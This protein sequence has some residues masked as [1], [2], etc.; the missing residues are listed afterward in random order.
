[1]WSDKLNEGEA[2]PLLKSK[3]IERKCKF[4]T[5]IVGA[6]PQTGAE[7]DMPDCAVKWLPPLLLEV[8]KETRQ[9]AAATESFR[10]AM[11]QQNRSIIKLT[12]NSGDKVE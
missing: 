4:F 12:D 8:I 3:C 10:N 5:Q 6:H 1:M 7:I 11:V 9:G 2:C